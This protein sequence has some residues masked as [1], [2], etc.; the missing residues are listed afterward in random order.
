[1]LYR[2]MF[3]FPRWESDPFKQMEQMRREMDR[4]FESFKGRR[5][6]SR[7]AG[8]FPLLNLTEDKDRYYVRAELPGIKPDE[9]DIQVTG[10]AL[11]ISGERKIPAENEK[12]KYYRRERDAG[13]FSR[14]INLPGEI[15]SDKVEASLVNGILTVAIAKAEIAKP[16]RISI[17]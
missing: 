12:A 3:D 7:R 17:K 15:D 6:I 1:M 8:V 16:K 11:S 4:L 5:F 14:I 10:K 9:L 2:R 13:K